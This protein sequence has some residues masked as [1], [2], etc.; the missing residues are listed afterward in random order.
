M[1]KIK[2]GK[3][4]YHLTALDNLESIIKNGLMSRYELQ[5]IKNK[6]VDIANQD[7]I[8]NREH[9]SLSSYIPFHFHIHTAFDTIVKKENPNTIFIYLCL[10]REKAKKLK[11]KIIPKH[12]LSLWD[13]DTCNYSYEEGFNKIDWY[14]MEL[15]Q[16]EAC[17]E[18]VDLD[19]HRQVRMA[20]CLTDSII[21]ITEFNIIG[22]PDNKSKM[23]VEN[24]FKKYNIKQP[25]YINTC[26][27]WF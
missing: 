20:E 24:L 11:F 27:N 15:T 7:I 2:D 26:K 6:F 18:G 5:K 25:P 1:G 3:L 16:K 9:Y 23:I 13:F 17:E 14:I 22:V 8:Q 10:Q 4:L 21:Q 12:P 19:E